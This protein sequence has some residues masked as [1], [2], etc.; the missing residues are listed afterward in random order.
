[1]FYGLRRRAAAPKTESLREQ[2][3]LVESAHGRGLELGGLWG[4]FQ[5]KPPQDSVILWDKAK[6]AVL[7]TTGRG[8]R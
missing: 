6:Q 5:P 3:G 8:H 1:M 7:R 4:P 2:P